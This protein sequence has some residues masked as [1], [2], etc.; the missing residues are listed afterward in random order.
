M[1]SGWRRKAK[2]RREKEKWKLKWRRGGREKRKVV[3]NEVR[4]VDVGQ[5]VKG[6]VTMVRS[7]GLEIKI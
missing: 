5:M 4:E 2:R 1:D 3:Q 6:I 7:L